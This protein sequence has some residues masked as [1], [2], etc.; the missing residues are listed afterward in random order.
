M[1]G[2]NARGYVCRH[3]RSLTLTVLLVLT[4]TLVLLGGLDVPFLREFYWVRTHP[5]PA[6]GLWN[7]P[8]THSLDA[9]ALLWWIRVLTVGKFVLSLGLARL[10]KSYH[11]LRRLQEETPLPSD[12]T[13]E[14]LDRVG[15]YLMVFSAWHVLL[16]GVQLLTFWLAYLPQIDVWMWSQLG[17]AP[18][19]ATAGLSLESLMVAMAC[20]YRKQL[21][22]WNKFTKELNGYF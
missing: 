15:K 13:E 14:A 3:W 7:P 20:Y 18:M 21:L 8:T 19:L 17:P 5:Y 2:V 9:F 6:Q 16:S 22:Q 4:N 12:Q 11:A 1:T 10:L